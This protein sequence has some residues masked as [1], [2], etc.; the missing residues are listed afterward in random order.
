M[1]GSNAAGH[2]PAPTAG[3][4]TGASAAPDA[5]AQSTR[6]YEDLLR[7]AHVAWDDLARADDGSAELS[8]GVLAA[9]KT[10]VRAEV[11]HGAQVDAPPTPHGP[12]TVSELS[13][14]TL[15]RE[16]VDAVPGAR[17]LRTRIE[18]ADVT[19]EGG[20]GV[21]EAVLC[22]ISAATGTRSLPE[23][24][25]RVRHEVA[26]ALEVELDVHLRRVDVHIEDL[27]EPGETPRSDVQKGSDER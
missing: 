18:H 5:D 7:T 26:S 3:T 16:A 19:G 15:L 1:N 25:E 27:H 10:A 22:R 21:P 24:A 9:I 4:G 23:L 2:G 17:S 14:R 12:Y 20:R 11:R 13:L 8:P 6:A